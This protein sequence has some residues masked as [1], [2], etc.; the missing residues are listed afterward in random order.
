M[1]P[2][3]HLNSPVYIH[4]SFSARKP[5]SS[6]DAALGNSL[7]NIA[8]PEKRAFIR[9]GYTTQMKAAAKNLLSL[10]I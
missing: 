8:A 3:S 6:L 2:E 10:H 1:V 4:V 7:S 9:L 5:A